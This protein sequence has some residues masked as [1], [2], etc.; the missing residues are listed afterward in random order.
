MPI[1]EPDLALLQ[2]I[3]R[4]GIVAADHIADRVFRMEAEDLITARRRSDARLH[5]LV[6]KGY[7][8][9]RPIT[10]E[11]SEASSISDVAAVVG[12]LYFTEAYSVTQKANLD[13]GVPLPPSLQESFVEHHVK[14]MEAIWRVE[15]T[16]RL[17][18]YQIAGWK[19]ESDLI[20]DSFKGRVFRD[21]RPRQESANAAQLV[22]DLA[23][24]DD[25][26]DEGG[27]ALAMFPDAVLAVVPPGSRTIET[28]NIEYVSRHYTDQMIAEKAA[29]FSGTTVWAADT[30]A[31]ASRVERITGAE[32]LLV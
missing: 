18:G 22:L 23:G 14:S 21:L 5:L 13:F 7:L 17:R 26:G 11:L 2:L 8:E 16:Y 15:L 29:A 32:A 1:P 24:S 28:I 19:T 27:E 10:L 4:G 31:T 30:A 3:A 12:K 20:R 25:A 9:A 6:L